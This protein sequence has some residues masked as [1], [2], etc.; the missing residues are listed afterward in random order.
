MNIDQ[1]NRKRQHHT[2]N[3]TLYFT[4]KVSLPIPFNISIS[5]RKREE[6]TKVWHKNVPF[7]LFL[8]LSSA[9]STLQRPE[10]P[11]MLEFFFIRE[12]FPKNIVSL[13][14][15]EKNERKNSSEKL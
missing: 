6:N 1:L 10:E 5:Y 14:K 11:S 9:Q 7:Q 12:R 8:I 15:I 4:D 2:N 13:R 3:Y